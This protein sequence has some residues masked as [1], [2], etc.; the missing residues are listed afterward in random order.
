MLDKGAR[1]AVAVPAIGA[2]FGASRSFLAQLTQLT[3]L[4]Q[5]ALIAIGLLHVVVVI[6]LLRALRHW[7]LE[8]VVVVSMLGL[9]LAYAAGRP[10]V[11]T[12][13]DWWPT[14]ILAIV[15]CWVLAFGSRWR[16]WIGG[17]CLA[18][19]AMLR[20]SSV[21]SSGTWWR[22]GLADLVVSGQWV[23]TAVLGVAA[24]RRVAIRSD[25]AEQDRV[26]ALHEEAAGDAASARS[27]R[28]VRFLHDDVIHA[29]R[30]VA[31][32][33]WGDPVAVRQ[34]AGSTAAR[35]QAGDV[36]STAPPADDLT[37]RLERLDGL[38]GVRVRVSG[39]APKLPSD[40]TEAF[41]AAAA[42][43]VRNVARHAGT[44]AAGIR[45]RSGGSGVV[46]SIVD[47]GRGMPAA[48]RWGTGLTHSVAGRMAEI[49]GAVTIRSGKVG[50]T[51]ELCSGRP[52]ADRVDS[53][54]RELTRAMA[55][56][57][58]PGLVCT[59]GLGL[60]MLPE[61]DTPMLALA[62]LLIFLC[63]GVWAVLRGVRRAPLRSYAVLVLG[64]VAGF[65]A[66]IF[67]LSPDTTNGH[68]LFLVG[69]VSALLLVI[70]IQHGLRWSLT[71]VLVVWFALFGLGSARFGF[72]SLTRDLSG[73]LIAPLVVLGVLAPQ[74]VLSRF[75]GRTL[76][77]RDATLG[78]RLRL[79]HLTNRECA[80]DARLRRTRD[81]VGP[82]LQSVA[83]GLVDLDDPA[84]Q[85]Q[86]LRLEAGVRDELK[87][88]A[89]GD[90]LALAV[91]GVRAAGWQL[92]LRIPP[93]ERAAATGEAAVLLSALGAHDPAVRAAFLSAFGQVGLVI[94][95]PTAAKL[96]E[97][98]A[99]SAVD[100]EENETW[101][102]LTARNQPPITTKEQSPRSAREL[103]DSPSGSPQSTITL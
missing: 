81:R 27:R 80:E 15:L 5:S 58:V 10:Q 65:A 88:G 42:E 39:R 50:T 86:A 79:R 20:T 57:V 33:D 19:L 6:L 90:P 59:T 12:T 51:V 49:G 31:Q 8:V 92:E 94:Q 73:A 82:F 103:S 25:R 54:W 1:W 53:T 85:R 77:A 16:W 67:A 100:L 34:L 87:F 84:V 2:L 61:V 30:A 37:A 28:V 52:A 4:G 14:S 101:C 102:R 36:G 9:L 11:G 69:G 43:A 89:A 76:A 66:N 44:D 62:G 29:L 45:V 64:A 78:S 26:K 38:A 56:M 35:L 68:H 55:P 48:A 93:A 72:E 22:V 3:V 63:C 60:L 98:R 95:E 23:L 74:A 71:A 97:W 32:P 47:G 40:M 83:D 46:V 24:V 75:V 21:G 91:D 18:L 99:C 70:A 7:C 13:G 17:V 41:V 96:R